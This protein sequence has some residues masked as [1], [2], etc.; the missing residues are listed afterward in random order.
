MHTNT[1][2]N[3][4]T[5]SRRAFL[6]LGLAGLAGAAL[7]AGQTQWAQ[8]GAIDAGPRREAE[9]ARPLFSTSP[10]T[11]SVALM[12]DDGFVNVARL[13]DLCRAAGVTLTLFPMGSQIE[14]HPEL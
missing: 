8:A 6:K 7:A 2:T 4:H 1:N 3:A 11:P 9:P 12:F 13:L 10:L 5:T 14:K